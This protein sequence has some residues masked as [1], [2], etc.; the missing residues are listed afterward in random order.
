MTTA[1]VGTT[2]DATAAFSGGDVTADRL[3]NTVYT[4]G[5]RRRLCLV[6][7]ICSSKTDSR[8]MAGY[9]ASLG[10]IR[11][12]LPEVVGLAVGLNAEARFMLTFPVD[13]KGDYSV[14]T[15]AELSGSVTI[16]Q[17]LEIDL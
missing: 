1:P 10:G 15:A 11:L 7:I 9:T 13:P 17:W 6:S 8:A 3:A 5:K 12:L 2:T 16:Q 14:T 4:N